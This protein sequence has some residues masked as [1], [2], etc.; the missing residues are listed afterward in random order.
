[1]SADSTNRAGVLKL[2]LLNLVGNAAVL[3]VWYYWLLIPDAHG[4]QVAWSAVLALHGAVRALAARGNA[5]VVSGCRVS[6]PTRDWRRVP[7]RVPAYYSA[8]DLGG[9]GGVH[10]V[11]DSQSRQL[12]PSVRGVDPAEGECRSVAAQR[13]AC[14]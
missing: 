9:A 3:A 14:F 4:W 1:M 2:W 6:Q 5:G 10:R 7:P 12:H 8:G 11:D 13:D